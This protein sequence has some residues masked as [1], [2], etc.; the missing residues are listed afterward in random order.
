VLQ[1]YGSSYLLSQAM[2]QIMKGVCLAFCTP[3][4]NI[5]K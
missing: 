3:K 4:H 1:V 5:N 2:E